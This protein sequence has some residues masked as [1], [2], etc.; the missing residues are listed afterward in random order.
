MT[1]PGRGLAVADGAAT[2][3]LPNDARTRLVVIRPTLRLPRR[4]DCERETAPP[5]SN[6]G[7]LL[8]WATQFSSRITICHCC[9]SPPFICVFGAFR[10]TKTQV[11]LFNLG[12]RRPLFTQ[13]I[14]RI[15]CIYVEVTGTIVLG[16]MRRGIRD[17][18]GR[19]HA[20]FY[21]SVGARRSHLE[22]PSAAR[23]GI[24]WS[25]P[26]SSTVQWPAGPFRRP[27][28]PRR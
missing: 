12:S 7:V 23:A 19:P 16:C 20:A 22:R 1:S 9:A 10:P 18:V 6:I 8:P 11:L 27:G 13:N 24:P 26:T 5:F 14:P 21:D 17:W 25:R 2:V 15:H 3:R 4:Q 28:R